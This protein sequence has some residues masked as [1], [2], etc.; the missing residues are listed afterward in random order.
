MAKLRVGSVDPREWKVHQAQRLIKRTYRARFRRFFH[1]VQIAPVLVCVLGPCFK[2]GTSAPCFK[3]ATGHP[4][5]GLSLTSKYA[6][7]RQ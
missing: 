5:P 2:G 1:L 4:S 3:H 6:P 7:A